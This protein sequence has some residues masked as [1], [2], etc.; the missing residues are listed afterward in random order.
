MWRVVPLLLLVAAARAT[1]TTVSWESY[2]GQNN[3]RG[4]FEAALSVAACLGAGTRVLL[5]P[6]RAA[7]QHDSA[8]PLALSPF[9]DVP[10]VAVSMRDLAGVELVTETHPESRV[11]VLE[12]DARCRY[13]C[14]YVRRE[15]AYWAPDR[16]LVARLTMSVSEVLVA[17]VWRSIGVSPPVR[18]APVLK[19]LAR[20]LVA[21]VL[22][23]HFGAAHLRL[24]DAV[25]YALVNCAAGNGDGAGDSDGG[26]ALA[27]REKT[28]GFYCALGG[29]PGTDTNPRTS[30]G[31]VLYVDDVLRALAFNVSGGAG[32]G[33]GPMASGASRLLF[34]ATNAP[35]S[36][37]VHALKLDAARERTTLLTLDDALARSTVDVR[38]RYDRLIAQTGSPSALRSALE[39]EVCVLSDAYVASA[40]STWDHYVL[41]ERAAAPPSHVPRHGAYVRDA[42]RVSSLEE[43]R[44]LWRVR[45]RASAARADYALFV[46]RELAMVECED[47]RRPPKSWLLLLVALLVSVSVVPASAYAYVMFRRAS[48]MDPGRG[49]VWYAFVARLCV[50]H[51]LL[52]LMSCALLPTR[53]RVAPLIVTAR[54]V[55][56]ALVSAAALAHA[57]ALVPARLG[58]ALVFALNAL[59][60]RTLRARAAASGAPVRALVDVRYAQEPSLVVQQLVITGLVCGC[61]AGMAALV[62][63]APPLG[64]STKK[65]G[66]A[67]SALRTSAAL[68]AQLVLVS[69]ALTAR[70]CYVLRSTVADD[71]LDVVRLLCE[72]GTLA[73]AA[74]VMAG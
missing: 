9:V 14:A 32:A 43:L 63:S 54:L 1:P 58:V 68:F 39:Q 2:S 24:G 69:L 62:G 72:L 51:A 42:A 10:H 61:V 74:R 41:R 49:A 53:S 16:V 27:L 22:G 56:T 25:P 52:T 73:L 18:A 40:G 59:A 26:N 66:R 28:R 45:E 33:A 11:A 5:H 64:A 31:R 6:Y 37:R 19:A 12:L 67:S 8:A 15:A 34:V 13:S 3:Q 71:V 47:E 4:A 55:V 57:V 21:S 17:D 44:A 36:V 48:F 38:S 70:A 65:A 7:A 35:T 20:D 60:A 46:E 50:A 29:A 30:A 23:A